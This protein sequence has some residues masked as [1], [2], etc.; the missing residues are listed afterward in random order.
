MIKENLSKE[1]LQENFA[2]AIAWGIN[3]KDKIELASIIFALLTSMVNFHNAV[4]DGKRW[5]SGGKLNWFDYVK[6]NAG[7][8][9]MLVSDVDNGVFVVEYK[10]AA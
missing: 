9:S 5:K 4:K 3:N 6:A 2:K 7:E 8:K 1:K 10:E